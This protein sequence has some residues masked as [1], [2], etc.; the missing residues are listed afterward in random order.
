MPLYKHKETG[1]IVKFGRVRITWDESF[2]HTTETCLDTQEVISDNYDF[3]EYDGT[4]NVKM[5][6]AQNDGRGVR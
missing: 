2:T 5:K 1:E 3:V 4:Y 6:K